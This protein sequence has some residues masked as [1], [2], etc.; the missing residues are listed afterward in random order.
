[1]ASSLFTYPLKK[2][3]VIFFACFRFLYVF[4]LVSFCVWLLWKSLTPDLPDEGTPVRFYSNQC[5]QDLTLTFLEAIRKANRSVDLAIFGLTDPTILKE[6]ERKGKRG[7]SPTIY[8]DLN[9]SPNLSAIL[10]H[11]QLHPSYNRG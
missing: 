1:M 8:Y 10:P 5:Q 11:C 7:I 9:H 4:S 2:G 3:R 6:L